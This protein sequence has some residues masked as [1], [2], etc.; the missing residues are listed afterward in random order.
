MKKLEKN[1]L[2]KGSKSI[3]NNKIKA[4]ITSVDKNTI[5]M[6]EEFEEDQSMNIRMKPQPLKQSKK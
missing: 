1:K 2:I 3:S 5:T 6:P 4:K